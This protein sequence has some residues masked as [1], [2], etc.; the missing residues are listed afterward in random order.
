MSASTEKKNRIAAREAGLDKKTLAAQEAAKK[1][2]ASKR[3][4][5]I[6]TVAVI[7]VIALVLLFNTALPYT[8]TTAVT[9]DGVKYSPAEVQYYMSTQYYGFVNQYGEYASL[10]GL[11]T[12][13]GVSGLASQP[14]AM[15]GE[16]KTWRDYFIDAGTAQMSQVQALLK[17][18]DENGITLDDADLA[19]VDASVEQIKASAE[20]NDYTL[21]DFLAAYYGGHVSVKVVK[22]QLAKTLLADKAFNALCESYD[23][24]S[25]E[26]KEAY[27]AMDGA[28]DMFRF[29]FYNVEAA[30][31]ETTDA[32]GNT[33]NEYT[34]ATLADAKAVAEE[35]VA[36]YKAAGKANSAS[37]VVLPAEG[38]EEAE[39]AAPAAEPT[40]A[41]ALIAQAAE[42]TADEDNFNA[43]IASVVPG[44]SSIPQ[45]VTG[46][47]VN[48]AYS[49]WMLGNVKSGDTT[50]IETASGA[51]VVLFINR[52]D[53][54]YAP[55][56]VRHILVSAEADENGTF[57]DEALEAAYASAK[58]IYDEWLAGEKTEESFAAL[59][60][61]KSDDAGS[62]ADGG[63]YENVT[64]GTTVAAFND[65]CFGD[66]KSGDTAIVYGSNGAYAGFHVMYFVSAAD[67]LYCDSIAANS[68]L[69]D[70]TGE[71]L[72]SSVADMATSQHY[73]LRLV[74]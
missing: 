16:G 44:A 38:E 61:E 55:V 56:N 12:N 22:E 27:K 52:D 34:E 40:E 71:W 24:S 70:A 11:N 4:W 1:A 66:R 28:N 41:Q 68:L 49:D 48:P 15:A 33:T 67:E 21:Q 43:A 7:V 20:A 73:W 18:A 53:N 5:T 64:K 36:A 8:G 39:E 54:N 59:A 3:K 47:S 32:D 65:F 51:T 9:I 60:V 63:L 58:A 14:C 69:N 62:S 35:I 72:S 31:E 30:T 23:F 13:Y 10:F 37:V 57:S 25:E 26:L 42:T 74:G 50:V 46:S 45:L 6:G 19:D 17:Y 29:A 2:A